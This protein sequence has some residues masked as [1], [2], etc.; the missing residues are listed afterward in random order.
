VSGAFANGLAVVK[1]AININPSQGAYFFNVLT[2]DLTHEFVE[3][4]SAHS[5]K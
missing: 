1:L 5:S 2:T 3:E 4:N